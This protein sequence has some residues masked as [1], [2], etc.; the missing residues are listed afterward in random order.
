[1]E[2]RRSLLWNGSK[3]EQSRYL[4]ISDLLIKWGDL[5][6]GLSKQS[7]EVVF[8]FLFTAYSEVRDN[9]DELKKGLLKGRLKL[10][11]LKILIVFIWHTT[12]KVRNGFWE[13]MKS[14]VL[15]RKPGPKVKQ[16]VCKPVRSFVKVS[17]RSKVVFQCTIQLYKRPLKWLGVCQIFQLNNK[18]SR[19]L[20]VLFLGVH[21]WIPK[22]K[23]AY[24]KDVFESRLCLMEQTLIRFTEDS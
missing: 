18:S 11:V 12:L 4:V 6:K 22:K 16:K 3:V 14:R 1:M 15:P 13:K 8:S 2:E 23:R 24:L 7:V 20:R 17:E 5:V 21:S 19:R 9:E 10:V